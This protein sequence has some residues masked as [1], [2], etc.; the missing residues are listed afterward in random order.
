MPKINALF[1]QLGIS[2]IISTID[3]IIVMAIFLRKALLRE[4]S[5]TIKCTHLNCTIQQ[6]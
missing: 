4:N 1:D 5:H 6:F 3:Y 2:K